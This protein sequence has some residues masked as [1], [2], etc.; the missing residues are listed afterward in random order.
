VPDDVVSG[1]PSSAVEARPRLETSREALLAALDG[2]DGASFTGLR[3]VGHEEY[4]ILS[5][6]ENDAN[7]DR[8]HAE[9]VQALLSA[10]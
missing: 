3:S 8:E 1:A 7:H 4:S 6:L 2:V 10:G 9:Q 5:V